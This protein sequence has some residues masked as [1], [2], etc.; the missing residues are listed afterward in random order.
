MTDYIVPFVT[1][2]KEGNP[3]KTFEVT[4]PATGKVVHLCGSATEADALAAID[5]AAAAGPGWQ[6]FTPG[7]RRDILL[8][9]A[10]LMNE[11]RDELR[12]FMIDE[13]GSTQAW[14]D[15]N[16][17]VTLDM[18]KDVAG[19]VCTLTGT[20]P[21]CSDPDRGAMILREPYGV[22]FAMAPWNAPYILGARA[23]LFPIAAGCTVVFKGSEKCPRVMHAIVSI[24]HEAGLPK[25][26][27]NY[28]VTEPANAPFVAE[29]IISNQNVKKINFTG[30]TPVGRIVGR[31]AGQYLKPLV[32]E[33]GGKAP[34]IVWKDA[35]L[36]RA[37][38]QCILG[39]F[40]HAGQICMSTE[41]IIVHKEISKPFQDKLLQAVETIFPSKGD[42]PVLIEAQAVERNKSLLRDAASKGASLLNGYIDTEESSK[43]RMRPV[44][45]VKVTPEMDIYKQESFGPT[46]SL[47]EIETEEEA[48]RIANDTEHGLSSAV[49]TEDLRLGL[50]FARGIESGAV[51]INNMTV[52][53]EAALPHGGAKASGYGR[54]NNS[55][56]L[57]EWVRTKTVTW[58][59]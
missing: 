25:G 56:G 44:V 22:V 13:T 41:K 11:R 1:N 50:R 30:S 14:A 6:I 58:N 34:A 17:D 20:V 52:H 54:F 31:L 47:I 16:L 37:A 57:D 9:G 32:L 19:R 35:N 8:K 48:L 10:A 36:D 4:S 15:F 42:A 28:L 51:H 26:V 49:F 3:S 2:G 7:R 18:F 33:L 45:V 29:T 27:L 12:Q 23:V 39:S 53:D 24:L 21:A 38:E 40:L 55:F 46:V 43:T 5:A 59:S